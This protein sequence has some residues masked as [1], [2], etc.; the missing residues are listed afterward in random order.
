MTACLRSRTLTKTL[1]FLLIFNNRKDPSIKQWLSKMSE[2]FEINSDNYP[3]D[4]SKL[5]YVKNKVG[6]KTL[7]LLNT[8]IHINLITSFATIKAL[9]NHLEDIFGNPYYKEHAIEKFQKLKLGISWFN[10][11]YSKFFCLTSDI[12]YTSDML[13]QKFQHKLTPQL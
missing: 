12:K 5:I 13:I 8:C 2:Q 3:I 1:P 9:F 11:F 7:Q 6:E 4:W 10:N